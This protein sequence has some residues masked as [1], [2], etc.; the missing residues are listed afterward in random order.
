[1]AEEYVISFP[2]KTFLIGE[3]AVLEDAPCVLVNTEPRFIF[4]AVKKSIQN[5]VSNVSLN[6][7]SLNKKTNSKQV[8]FHSNSPAQQWLSR[9]PLI[10]KTY[11]IQCLNP[12]QNLGG[13]GYSTAQFAYLYYL[14]HSTQ[15]CQ[16]TKSK[17]QNFIWTKSDLFHIWKSYKSLNFKGCRP[18]GADLMS[19]WMGRVCVFYPHPFKVLSIDWPFKGLDFVLVHTGVKLNTWEH[20]EK[21]SKQSAQKLIS[22]AQVAVDCF[23][24]ADPKGFIGAIQNYGA[25]LKEL[26]LVHPKTLLLL[27]YISNHTPIRAVK[28]C[29]AMGAEVVCIFFNSEH[30]KFVKDFLQQQMLKKLIPKGNLVTSEDLSCGLKKH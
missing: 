4:S 28:G 18:S 1:M 8:V 11:D 29:G 25:V 27:D 17:N 19:Q 20:L 7:K 21:F 6:K 10:A 14:S 12:Y 24:C 5:L 30:K 22:L 16:S 3:Y 9:H 15:L 2:G 13:V 26:G 23:I